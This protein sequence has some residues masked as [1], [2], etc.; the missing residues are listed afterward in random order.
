MTKKMSIALITN[1]ER[2]TLD[3]TLRLCANS[4]NLTLAME[5]PIVQ[6]SRFTFLVASID[7]N[8]LKEVK[9]GVFPLAT[10]G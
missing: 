7:I 4:N 2:R 10:A 8:N 1:E 9:D 5:T 6:I 3:A